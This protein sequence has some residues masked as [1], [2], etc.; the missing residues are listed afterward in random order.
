MKVKIIEPAQ[1]AQKYTLL[2]KEEQNDLVGGG[3]CSPYNVTT[4]C[5]YYHTCGTSSNTQL[6]Q[7]ES[8]YVTDDVECESFYS[9]KEWCIV[10]GKCLLGSS[11]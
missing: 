11:C 10:A 5:A 6:S 2:A 7:A 4:P 8:A 1:V 9:W 3:N